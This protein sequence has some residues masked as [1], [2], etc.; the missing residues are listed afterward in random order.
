MDSKG[1]TI[2]CMLKNW[3]VFCV[4]AVSEDLKDKSY[5]TWLHKLLLATPIHCH[6]GYTTSLKKVWNENQKTGRERI[7]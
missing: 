5:I 4:Q 6:M 1:E 3:K 2:K 7:T